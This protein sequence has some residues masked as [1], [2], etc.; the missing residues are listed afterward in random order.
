[1]S[2]GEDVEVAR[3][4]EQGGPR[5]RPARAAQVGGEGG[6]EGGGGA[7]GGA[8]ARAGQHYGHPLVTGHTAGV[9]AV[10]GG[11]GLHPHTTV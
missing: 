1:M 6:V 10:G 11:R 5:P 3:H 2:V 4:P 9:A 8:A 7:G